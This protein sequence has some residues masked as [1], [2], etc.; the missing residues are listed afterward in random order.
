VL[1]ARH[2]RVPSSPLIA[3]AASWG[4][5]AVISK[6]AVDEIP[7]L[8]LLPTQLTVSV[9]LLRSISRATSSRPVPP[10]ERR[11]VAVLG[12]LNPG[13]AY[14]LSLA[15]LAL[16]PASVSVLLWAVEPVLIILLARL[17]L[18]DRIS[19]P[20]A[21][22]SLT[23]LVG[24]VLVVFQPG[25]RPSLAGVVLTLSGVAACAVYTVAS[26][27]YVVVAQPIAIVCLQ[28]H[29]ALAFSVVLFAGSLVAGGHSSLTTISPTAWLS[30]VVA[31]AF[32]YGVAFWFYLTGLRSVRP[33][34]AGM[35]INL[36]PVFGLVAGHAL[37]D[38][39]LDGRQWLGAA[40]II[41]AVGVT[42][43]GLAYDATAGGR[44]RRRATARR[45]LPGR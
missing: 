5:A 19:R 39:H 33:A 11:S 37:L 41:A 44:G 38:E 40:V 30:A 12:V 21:V 25:A 13:L 31:G 34:V 42:A 9:I 28:Q 8:T 29:A 7:P 4:V 23:A 45:R 26:S 10:L 1:P 32:Y 36:V 35:Y 18:G 2:R 24:V 17:V 3:A 20:L 6:R 14:A 22:A 15:G 43:T 16:I 27:R